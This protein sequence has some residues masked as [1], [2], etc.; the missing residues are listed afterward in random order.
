MITPR[1]FLGGLITLVPKLP[2]GNANFCPSSAWAKFESYIRI[3]S[4]YEVAKRSFAEKQVPKQ[5]LGNQK[6]TSGRV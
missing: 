4:L 2:L 1:F 6:I 3:H 5:E